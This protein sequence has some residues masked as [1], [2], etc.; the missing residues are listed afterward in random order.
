MAFGD[1]CGAKMNNIVTCAG[2]SILSA[3]AAHVASSLE[4]ANS[5]SLNSRL[6]A[7]RA[8]HAAMRFSRWI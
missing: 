1:R 5:T 7:S 4:L 6:N 3:L 2:I 8:K